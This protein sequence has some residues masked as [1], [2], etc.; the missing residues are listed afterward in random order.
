MT[1]FRRKTRLYKALNELAKFEGNSD[2][3]SE[4]ASSSDAKKK[5]PGE[6]G[7]PGFNILS[8]FCRVG[9]NIQSVE[10]LTIRADEEAEGIPVVVIPDNSTSKAGQYDMVASILS[11]Q[12]TGMLGL[13]SSKNGGALWTVSDDL[14]VTNDTAEKDETPLHVVLISSPDINPGSVNTEVC[15][16]AMNS[17]PSLELS[18]AIPYLNIEFLSSETTK[19]ALAEGA[20]KIRGITT[21]RYLLGEDLESSTTYKDFIEAPFYVPVVEEKESKRVTYSAMDIFTSPQTMAPVDVIGPNKQLRDPFRPFMSV[22]NFS[23]TVASPQYGLDSLGCS[24]TANLSLILH[25]R[26]RLKDIAP[27]V[28]PG[29]FAKGDVLKITYGYAHPDGNTLDQASSAQK[30]SMLYGHIIDA[31]RVTE[32]FTVSSADFSLQESGE[33]KI[34]IAAFS[35]GVDQA[36]SSIDVTESYGETITFAKV[37]KELNAIQDMIALLTKKEKFSKISTPTLLTSQ[38]SLSGKQ[39]NL[40]TYKELVS[41][42]R[43]LAKKA[44]QASEK[45]ALA[46][47]NNIFDDIFDRSKG[48]LTQ[49][50]NARSSLLKKIFKFLETSPDPF[51]VPHPKGFKSL[52]KTNVGYS[53]DNL[54]KMQDLTVGKISPSY[55]S[56]G[57]LLTVLVGTSIK[58]EYQGTVDEIQMIFYGFNDCAAG[59]Q[60]MNIASMPLEL[61][62]VKKVLEDEYTKRTSMSLTTLMAV[63]NE[64]FIKDDNTKA[65]GLTK[66]PGDILKDDALKIIYNPE[67]SSE[68]PDAVFKKP[69]LSVTSRMFPGTSNGISEDMTILRIEFF[70]KRSSN[71]SVF[72]RLLEASSDR[73]IMYTL[74]RD[75][76]GK[77]F[78]MQHEKSSKVYEKVLDPYLEALKIPDGLD[79]KDKTKASAEGIAKY[80]KLVNLNRKNVRSV[81]LEGYQTIVYGGGATGIISANV[82]S[83]KDP[84]AIELAIARS[85]TRKRS[86][87]EEGSP[88]Q[89]E[90]TAEVYPVE[91]SL[92]TIGCPYFNFGQEYFIDFGSGTTIDNLYTVV[93]ITH[94]INNGEFTTNLKLIQQEGYPTLITE[95]QSL[96]KT[97]EKLMISKFT[98]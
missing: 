73:G 63:V 56:L 92:Q 43:K 95:R 9:E 75:T 45:D 55:I 46:K 62:T 53:A 94:S 69:E 54:A 27:L 15:T 39:I 82:S 67:S 87:E 12:I 6:F 85:N 31:M 52:G 50:A 41:F 60:D 18:K 70:D 36:F 98:K 20:G 47:I 58:K 51:I 19:E 38:G 37:Q 74:K 97:I 16:V 1:A 22:E 79:L 90:F 13:G 2:F 17:L 77:P 96:N 66:L 57:K 76:G 25:D 8:D 4:N 42:K 68:Y 80:G 3:I 24:V 65:Y 33:M 48:S 78:C 7:T 89:D 83:R 93:D 91:C 88:G 32:L 35:I 14:T 59:V 44:N 11:P 5:I 29:G 28:T 21:S 84:N 10:Y 40:K 64:N 61:K 30:S 23:V 34:D 71:G 72:K 86:L 49:A 26:K 81:M